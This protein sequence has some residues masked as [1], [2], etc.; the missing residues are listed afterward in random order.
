MPS[1]AISTRAPTSKPGCCVEHGVDVLLGDIPPLA[2][3]A[4]ARAGI[5]S[6]A[7]GN[8]GWDWIYAAWPDFD[9]AIA[10]VQAGYRQAD[11]LLR[12]PLHSPTPMRS[13]PST[14][15]RTCR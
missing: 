11:V 3:A 14:R 9:A 12:L 5:P 1:P 6:V 8:F 13:P 15:S 2:F 7:L 10:A 4:A